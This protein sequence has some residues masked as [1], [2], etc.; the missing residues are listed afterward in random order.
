MISLIGGAELSQ[1]SSESSIRESIVPPASR[2]RNAMMSRPT[3]DGG[4]A[5]GNGRH[6]VG[7]DQLEDVTDFVQ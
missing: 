5:G 6:V 2:M 7:D 1:R 3:A 4:G